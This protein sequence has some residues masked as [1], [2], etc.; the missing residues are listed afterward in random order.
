MASFYY[1]DQNPSGFYFL[2]QIIILVFHC[3]VTIKVIS[4][5]IVCLLG[6]RKPLKI[7]IQLTS[8]GLIFPT[9]VFYE[10]VRDGLCNSCAIFLWYSS[11]RCSDISWHANLWK[12]TYLFHGTT[13]NTNWLLGDFS[14]DSFVQQYIDKSLSSLDDN[15]LTCRQLYLWPL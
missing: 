4:S 12:N 14:Q 7:V 6:F 3:F 9:F 13:G 2:V 8:E 10:K 15:L 11:I 1:Y 5:L